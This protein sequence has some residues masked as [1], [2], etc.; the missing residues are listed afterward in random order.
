[1]QNL[2][3]FI[4]SLYRKISNSLKL[5]L[6]ILIWQD[7]VISYKSSCLEKIW[8]CVKPLWIQ[9]HIFPFSFPLKKNS[10]ERM[11]RDLHR[12]RRAKL[13][14]MIPICSF[15]LSS[16][17]L[18]EKPEPDHLSI[19]QYSFLHQQLQKPCWT[20]FL[21]L[22]TKVASKEILIVHMWHHHALATWQVWET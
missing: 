20:P 16:Q 8:V 14:Q 4:F 12:L 9:F 15:Y 7:V 3:Y 18:G 6:K 2:S 19:R 1:M 5:K 10:I 22:S 17:Q 11:E 21:L 13:Q